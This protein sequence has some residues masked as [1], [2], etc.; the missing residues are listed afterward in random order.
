MFV[1]E[2]RINKRNIVCIFY[3]KLTQIL[4]FVQT[5]QIFKMPRVTNVEKMI[6]ENGGP[7]VW[8]YLPHKNA[9][10]CR[11]CPNSMFEVRYKSRIVYHAKSI[12]HV[13]LIKELNLPVNVIKQ[14][15]KDVNL[16]FDNS[17]EDT[18]ASSEHNSSAD[19]MAGNVKEDN[20]LTEYADLKQEH[21]SSFKVEKLSSHQS[22][23][24]DSHHETSFGA[25]EDEIEQNKEDLFDQSGQQPVDDKS[26]FKGMHQ[27]L[28]LVPKFARRMNILVI[29]K[30][31]EGQIF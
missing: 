11:I 1:V 3:L 30:V 28:L 16:K 29:C 26:W 5:G 12:K 31:V 19:Y 18:A 7:R 17:L 9:L 21:A 14:S 23:L 22:E 13:R 2:N 6:E 15:F 24:Q 25:D 27:D 20:N 4:D 8:F 10:E